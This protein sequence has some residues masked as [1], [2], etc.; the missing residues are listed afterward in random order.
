[1]VSKSGDDLAVLLKVGYR[2][3]GTSLCWYYYIKE[4]DFG[5]VGVFGCTHI[6]ESVRVA[7]VRLL[8]IYGWLKHLEKGRGK[9]PAGT[10]D[11]K[12]YTYAF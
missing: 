8:P 3:G 2:K 1:L 9:R 12:K 6:S 7:W 4:R 10:C 11:R 5:D